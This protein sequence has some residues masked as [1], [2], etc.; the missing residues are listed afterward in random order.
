MGYIWLEDKLWT[1]DLWHIIRIMISLKIKMA[2][3]S[4]KW[5]VV[6]QWRYLNIK[7]RILLGDLLKD[8]LKF[9]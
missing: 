5:R 1:I 3:I 6:L 2:L 7:N 8:S 9:N 4:N